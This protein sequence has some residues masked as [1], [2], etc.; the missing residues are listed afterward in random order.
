MDDTNRGI[1]EKFIVRRFDGSHR[2][3]KKHGGCEYFVLDLSHDKFAGPAIRAYA[4]ACA[5]EYP[6]L[7]RDL[8]RKL[9]TR[10]MVGGRCR[11]CGDTE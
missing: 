7:S 5:T 11:V 9:P 3:G 4:E 1:Y 6:H 2:K 10:E 8:L